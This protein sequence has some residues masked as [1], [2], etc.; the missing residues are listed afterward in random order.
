M[1]QFKGRV[2][3]IEGSKITIN[4]KEETRSYTDMKTGETKIVT[5]A[6]SKPDV[7]KIGAVVRCN[8]H[9]RDKK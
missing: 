5:S 8:F 4:T 3:G 6:W 2:S 7:P 9:N 1:A